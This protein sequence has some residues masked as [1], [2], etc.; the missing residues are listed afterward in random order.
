MSIRVDGRPEPSVLEETSCISCGGSEYETVFEAYD[1]I[2]GGGPYPYV[3]CAGCG[4]V[5]EN[6]RIKKA[7]IGHYYPEKSYTW[8]ELSDEPKLVPRLMNRLEKHYLFSL[9]RK[10]KKHIDDYCREIGLRPESVLDLGCATGERLYLFRKDGCR[11]LG[12]EMSED[13]IQAERIYGVKVVNS[14]VEDFLSAKGESFDLITNYHIIEHFHDPV[15]VLEGMRGRLNDNGLLVIE[16]PNAASVQFRL[17]KE[18]CFFIEAPRHLYLFTPETL[19]KVLD[20]A[21]FRLAYYHTKKP[22][23]NPSPMILS[24][25]P[26]LETRRMRINELE[27]GGFSLTKRLALAA[28]VFGLAPLAY[29]EAAS[30]MGA[31]ITAFAV[32]KH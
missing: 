29:L 27:G 11:V 23:L 22:F 13:I 4:L 8:K 17:F 9:Y 12:V 20:K 16:T 30:G 24:L 19:G 3:R 6:P 25:V 10:E 31:T 5:Y 18:K 14:S 1:R 21:G 15:E 28:G 26:S 7:L 32:K 2:F